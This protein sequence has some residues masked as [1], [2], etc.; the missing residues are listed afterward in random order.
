MT[1]ATDLAENSDAAAQAF[2]AEPARAG[3]SRRRRAALAAGSI[4][5]LALGGVWLAR[6]T[7]ATRVI[8]AN[9]A[10]LDL[11][12]TYQIES[13]GPGVEVLR[14]VV[15]GDPRHPDLTI[16]RLELRPAYG[17]AGPRIGRLRIDGARL[18]GSH[19]GGKLSFGTLDKVLFAPSTAPF[20]LPDWQVELNDARGLI[21]SDLGRLAFKAEGQGNLRNGFAGQ[22]GLLVPESRVGGCRTGRVSYYGQVSI[23]DERPRIAGPLR[24]GELRC[25]AAGLVLSGG[26]ADLAL[27]ADKDLKG[28]A[29]DARGQTGA[30]SVGDTRVAALTL[31]TGLAWRN[32]ALGGRVSLRAERVSQPQATLAALS[33]DGGVH[34]RDGFS[35]V[36]LR[37]TVAGEDVRH[38]AAIARMLNNATAAASGTLIAPVLAQ[39]HGALTREEVGSRLSGEF[40]WKSGNAVVDRGVTGSGWSL[41]M[42]DLVLRARGGQR[43]LSASRL[44]VAGGA[45]LPLRLA[46]QFAS[47]GRGLPQ[48]FGRFDRGEQGVGTV[49]RARLEPYGS[50]T[51]RIGIPDLTVRSAA[52]G[53]ATLS[54]S[55]QAS[56]AF[57]GGTVERLNL[58]LEAT[59]SRQGD[60]SLWSRCVTPA[61]EQLTMASLVLTRQALTLC[62]QGADAAIVRGGTGGLRI[63]GRLPA[64]TLTGRLG[65]S[66]LAVAGGPLAFGYG[67]GAGR[68]NAQAL[69]ITIGS[70]ENLNRLHLDTFDAQ[71][72]KDVS[73]QFTGADARF[74]AVPAD[75]A[76]GTG[77]WRLADGRLTVSDAVFDLTDRQK[78]ARFEPLHAKD[79][80][81]TLADN[82]IDAD[83]RLFAPKT[84]G[85]VV[86]ATIHHD[87]I[88]KAGHADIA[89]DG[90]KFED[91]KD[92][93]GLQPA[94]LSK[95]ALGV[96][97][98]ANGTVTGKGRIDWKGDKLTSSGR[99]A[100]TGLDL[101]AAFGP[102][103][104]L[105]GALDFT[106]LI[107][108]VTAPHQVV[109]VASVNPGIEVNDGTVDLQ[110]LPDQVVVLNDARWPFLGGRLSLKPAVLHLAQTEVRRFTLVIDKL[111]AARFLERMDLS[112]LSATGVFDGQLPLE[113][114]GDKGR[115][116]GGNLVSRAPGGTVAYVGALTYKDL[117]PMA[118][119]AFAALKSMDYRTMIITMQGDLAGEIV[120]NVKFSGIKQGSAASKNFLTRQVANLPIQFNVNIRAPFL[121]LITSLKSMYDPASVRDPRTLGLISPRGKPVPNQAATAQ[122]A[123]TLPPG[124]SGIQ[125]SVIGSRP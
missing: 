45:G 65:E 34:V 85:E 117:S 93:A 39:A 118:N 30:L 64:L 25:P 38:G 40:V 49:L 86:H 26:Q 105:S 122:Q 51:D 107:G 4:V 63:G 14:N 73:G 83:A 61:F 92:N 97:A 116:V 79:A 120:T 80:T 35:N 72:G 109:R 71:A 41:A 55:A 98:N 10:D 44:Q 102:V 69:G 31:A 77:R 91:R 96:V 53:S 15:I 19:L 62:P 37:G 20:R 110:L 52:D 114:D 100:T 17:F 3:F 111:D 36:Q 121:Q 125:P 29:I 94:D 33:L 99:F 90:L 27:L 95:L 2:R 13:I 1:D 21:G 84:G 42:P 123:S 87:A 48:V 76:K 106:D 58:P 70:G 113:F 78:V 101:A 103:K 81:L 12:A 88:T 28:L 32:D 67:N 60:W 47:G 16:A 50:D 104:G 6:N 23:S 18:F 57:P 22:L 115:I 24:T 74:A 124:K 82:R 5:L 46:G 7:I 108:L 54:G 43:L 8:D 75:V 68:L 9:L 66:P 112:N 56:G 119:Y 59:I 89:V 11:P